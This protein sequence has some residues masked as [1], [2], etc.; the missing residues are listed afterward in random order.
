M[1]EI[2]IY[3]LIVTIIFMMVRI[4]KE[5]QENEHFLEMWRESSRKLSNLQDKFYDFI[6]V[7]DDNGYMSFEPVLKQKYNKEVK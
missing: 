2:I 5:K 7:E 4:Y 1:N 3:I 6:P